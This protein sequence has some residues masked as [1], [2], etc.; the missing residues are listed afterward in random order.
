MIVVEVVLED[1]LKVAFAD[2]VDLIEAFSAD[3]PAESFDVRILPRRSRHGWL[4]LNSK[5]RHTLGELVAVDAIAV[6]QQVF[7]RRL[8]R[9]G[10][11]DLL[12]GPSCRRRLGDGEMQH[13]P[14]IMQPP[15]QVRPARI[16]ASIA[17]AVSAAGVVES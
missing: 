17:A 3:S 8:E 6:A 1:L 5:G 12:P 7:G 16:T 4:L 15:A 11:D 9:E 13:L 14:T 10:V 2:D